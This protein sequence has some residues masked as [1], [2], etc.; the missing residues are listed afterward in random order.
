VFNV[1]KVRPTKSGH[2]FAESGAGFQPLPVTYLI[3]VFAKMPC[4]KRLFAKMPYVKYKIS[5]SHKYALPRDE[6]I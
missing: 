5:R 6:G 3:G 2:V 4:V 1:K